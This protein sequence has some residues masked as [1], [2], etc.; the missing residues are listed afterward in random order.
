MARPTQ[1]A[2]GLL[3]GAKLPD[4]LRFHSFLDFALHHQSTF[5]DHQSF[6]KLHQLF[7][8]QQVLKL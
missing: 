2:L 8:V 7:S 6:L 1:S 5:A 4:H 3:C